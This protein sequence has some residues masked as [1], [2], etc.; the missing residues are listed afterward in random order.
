MGL[1]EGRRLENGV[2]KPKGND[3][4]KDKSKTDNIK[5]KTSSDLYKNLKK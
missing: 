5:K 2:E 1:D 3:N 4:K